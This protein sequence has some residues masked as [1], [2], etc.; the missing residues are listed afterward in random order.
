MLEA[1]EAQ[2]D[3]INQ[4]TPE[5]NLDQTQEDAIIEHDL[6]ELGLEPEVQNDPNIE[7]GLRLTREYDQDTFEHELRVAEY[8]KLIAQENLTAAESSELTQAALLHDVGKATAVPIEIIHK[9]GVLTDEERKIVDT[10]AAAS[11]DYIAR[12]NPQ[13][14]EIV[15]IHHTVEKTDPEHM[16]ETEKLARCLAIAD[17]FD[18]LSSKRAY[19][20]PMSLE[21]CRQI[22]VQKFP[23]KEDAAM[24]DELILSHP[25]LG[26]HEKIQ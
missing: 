21:M 25:S 9:P 6:G 17:Q 3:Q 24:I 5:N 14:A 4:S 8:A 7:S 13:E 26:W 10:H 16:N 18:A 22:L 23:T 15:K 19:K 1:T 12:F 11:S 20:E 2:P